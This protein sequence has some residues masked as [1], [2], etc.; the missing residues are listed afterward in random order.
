MYAKPST[1][2]VAVTD[3]PNRMIGLVPTIYQDSAL[4]A[5]A[6]EVEEVE[7]VEEEEEVE[8][9]E[10][11]EGVEDLEVVEVVDK[12]NLHVAVLLVEVNSGQASP[13]GQPG[14]H[15]VRIL[16]RTQDST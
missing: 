6:E 2:S 10:E 1:R 16:F 5:K 9:V 13:G 15:E 12:A 4:E 11:V 14:E 8:E 3:A 7:E